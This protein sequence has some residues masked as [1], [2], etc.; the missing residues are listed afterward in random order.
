[1][2]GKTNKPTNKQI[3]KKKNEIRITHSRTIG[4]I[5]TDAVHHGFQRTEHHTFS[6]IFN[7]F[8]KSLQICSKGSFNCF[9][10][11]DVTRSPTN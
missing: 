8:I 11:V 6:H 3:I 2:N 9:K 4:T 7:N 1:M 5:F 10:L